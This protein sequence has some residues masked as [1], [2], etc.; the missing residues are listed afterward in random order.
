VKRHGSAAA[1]A[2][3][4]DAGYTLAPK[5]QIALQDLTPAQSR[6]LQ[7]K[8]KP[9]RLAARSPVFRQ[10]DVSDRL[11]VLDAGRIRIFQTSET[12]EDF[13]HGICVGGSTIGLTALLL[14]TPRTTSAETLEVSAISVMSRNDFHGFLEA[15]PRFGAG[16]A[17]LLAT[18]AT[19]SYAQTSSFARDTALIRLGRALL[20]L[21]RT[22]RQASPPRLE[23]SGLT[24]EDMATMIGVSRTWVALTLNM[25]AVQGLI[26]KE[27][28]HIVIPDRSRLSRFVERRTH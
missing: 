18:M 23:V 12:G 14:E 9:I 6:A 10:G 8:M 13:T 3:E 27:K 1:A 19:E 25:L 26:V 16:L 5:W 2:W 24:Q 20:S 22:D 17:K 28:R 15:M 7:E 21:A 4:I 11:I